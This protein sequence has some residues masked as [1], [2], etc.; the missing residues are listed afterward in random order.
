MRET[1][2]KSLYTK[3]KTNKDSYN[4]IKN[5]M[6]CYELYLFGGGVRDFLNNELNYFR[7]LDFVIKSKDNVDINIED[8]IPKNIK[9]KKNRFNG[10]KIY[11]DNCIIDIW[12]IKNTWA[13]KNNKL[14]NSVENLLKSVYLNIDSLLYSLN[15][16]KY[17]NNCDRTYKNI[18]QLDIVY[19]ETPYE[20]LNLL[21]ALIYRKKYA[22]T[23]SKQLKEKLHKQISN[24]N[25]DIIKEFMNLQKEHY[26]KYLL[27]ESELKKEIN[28]IK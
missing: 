26:N 11:F 7:D 20:N 3:L 15:E 2:I 25:N 23:F 5:L 6:K 21:R 28:Y 8:F 19:N 13:F 27:N 18:T 10:Y 17:I 9:F 14:D 1:L 12:D 22:L 4:F 24:T 16:N